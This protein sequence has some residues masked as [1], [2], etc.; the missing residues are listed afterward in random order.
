MAKIPVLK[1][2]FNVDAAGN[3]EWESVSVEASDL[4]L[5]VLPLAHRRYAL[6]ITLSAAARASASAPD[7][8]VA[9]QT[10]EMLKCLSFYA[11]ERKDEDLR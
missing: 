9:L 10:P 6:R 5:E 11:V 3:D 1:I 4:A 2:G 7:L 8:A